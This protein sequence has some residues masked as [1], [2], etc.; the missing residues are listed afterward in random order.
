[1][2][3][4]GNPRDVGRWTCLFA[5]AH[6]WQATLRLRHADAG[7]LLHQLRTWQF[8]RT[9]IECSEVDDAARAAAYAL[10]DEYVPLT[11]AQAIRFLS[12]VA[13]L[14]PHAASDLEFWCDLIAAAADEPEDYSEATVEPAGGPVRRMENPPRP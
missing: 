5:D 3:A 1:V 6:G 10:V 13:E 12:T 2:P 9:L 8:A 4:P 7:A 14:E 11:D